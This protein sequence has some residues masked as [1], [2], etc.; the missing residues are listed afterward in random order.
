MV[1][2]FR[3]SRLTFLRSAVMFIALND[4][5]YRL[6]ILIISLLDRISIILRVRFLPN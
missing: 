5:R 6:S 3:V 2:S 1:G 4:P